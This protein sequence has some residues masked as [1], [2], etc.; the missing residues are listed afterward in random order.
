M[1]KENGEAG[2]ISVR[3]IEETFYFIAGSKNVHLLFRSRED[4]EK[5]TDGRFS[6]ARM[7]GEAWLRQVESLLEEKLTELLALLHQNKLTMIFEIL[8][9]GYQHVVDLSYLS[10]PQ[11]KFLAFTDQYSSSQQEEPSLVAFAP[12]VSLEFA[13]EVGLDTANYETI[14]AGDAEE[15][16]ARVRRGEGYEGEVLYFMDTDGNT[17]GLLKKKTSWYVVL[18][19]IREKASHVYST[20]KKNPGGWSA[21]TNNLL[22]TKMNKRL[23]E[24]QNWLALPSDQV[25]SWKMAGR[26]FQNWLVRSMM[27]EKVDDLGKYSIRG[28]FPQVWKR[29]ISEQSVTSETDMNDCENDMTP[30]DVMTS[31]SVLEEPRASSP[32]LIVTEEARVARPHIGLFIVRNVDLMG[33]NLKKVLAAQNKTHGKVCNDRKLASIGFHDLDRIKSPRLV[34]STCQADTEITVMG[35]SSRRPISRLLEEQEQMKKYKHHLEHLASFPVILN[36]DTVISLPP[37]VNCEETKI[38][39]ETE[40]ILVEVTT[41]QTEDVLN[42]VVNALIL[43]FYHMA[44]RLNCPE[45]SVHIEKVK[46]VSAESSEEI[47]FP[48]KLP[49]FN[50]K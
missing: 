35:A 10:Q 18:R 45:K 26:N 25:L 37:L 39:D 41:D 44:I 14:S 24:I 19:A 15:R 31:D 46:L 2:H 1:V 21:Q 22:L 42:R 16:M 5:Y 3:K 50:K 32:H 40:H 23:D 20:Y 27:R 13:K 36:G 9:P 48:A 49:D 7:V 6:V 4:L 28:N 33:K 8:C 34:Y 47:H 12:D 30:G 17:I 11:L 38:S 43:Q 29:F